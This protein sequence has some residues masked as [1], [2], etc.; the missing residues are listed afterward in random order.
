MGRGGGGVI[1]VFCQIK[2]P[3]RP[4]GFLFV[5]CLFFA[6]TV[7]EVVSVDLCLERLTAWDPGI[8]L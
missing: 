5:W 2:L 3:Y 1:I 8:M 6:Y 4:L 7:R